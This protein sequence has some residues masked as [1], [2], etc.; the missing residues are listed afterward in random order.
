MGKKKLEWLREAIVGIARDPKGWLEARNELKALRYNNIN[1]SPLNG[2]NWMIFREELVG[3]PFY[4]VEE[5]IW[6]KEKFIS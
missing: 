5:E 2:D 6:L 1:I 3:K 4:I